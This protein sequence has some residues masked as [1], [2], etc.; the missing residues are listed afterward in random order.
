M[1]KYQ[2]E[3][4]KLNS[5]EKKFS[6]SKTQMTK[7]MELTNSSFSITAMNMGKCLAKKK[8]GNIMNELRISAEEWNL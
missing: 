3:T 1:I 6:R 7:M 8:M 4:G 2:R 5:T